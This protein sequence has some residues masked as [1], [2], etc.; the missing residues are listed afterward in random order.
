MTAGSPPID[1][2]VL[3]SG[4]EPVRDQ[5][6]AHFAADEELGVQIAASIDGEI[7]LDVAAGFA[8]RDRT[9]AMTRDTLV[10]VFSCSKPMAGLAIGWLVDQGRLSYD[11]PVAELWPAFGAEGKGRVTVAQALSHQAGVPGFPA[12]WQGRD[13]YDADKTASRLASL[14]PMWEPGTRTGYHP[15]TWGVIAGQIARAA[16]AGGRSLG[17]ILREE[18]A[19]PAQAD[20]WIGLPEAEHA[21]VSEIRRPS[22]YPDF[23]ELNAPTRA[24]FLESWSSVS[25]TPA[26]FRL[27]EFPAANGHGTARGLA[28]LAH[29][30]ARE[31][32]IGELRAIDAGVIEQ[33]VAERA[34]GQ[35][36]VLPAVVSMGAGL[37]RNRPD[38]LLY[39]PGARAVGHTGHGGSCVVADPDH[40][41]TFAYV[42]NRQSNALVLDPRADRLIK[43]LYKA[44]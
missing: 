6:L 5:M 1:D 4:L 11:Q 41:L 26:M 31:G 2:A 23:G 24:A 12:D 8:D 7:V 19:G 10:P 17:A 20:F 25:G 27:A 15:L 28:I 22:A 40:G 36:L 32:R 37:L 14:A 29:A 33:A 42:M 21:R 16:D 39:G 9:R 38:R 43:A 35:D 18:I 30:Y 13:W 44:L 3:A 34:E